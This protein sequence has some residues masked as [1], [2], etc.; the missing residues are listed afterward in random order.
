M[1]P[2]FKRRAHD[3]KKKNSNLNAPLQARE[4]EHSREPLSSAQLCSQNSIRFADSREKAKNVFELHLQKN[5]S[6]SV[7]KYQGRCGKRITSED[8]LTIIRSIGESWW[9]YKTIK[10]EM[11][12]V[13]SMY[14]HFNQNYLEQFNT[15]NLHLLQSYN[16]K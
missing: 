10:K 7:R 3:G 9:T 11:S 5:V 8:P 1:E 15:E 2:S 12:P 13:R 6:R 4:S 16:N 14:L